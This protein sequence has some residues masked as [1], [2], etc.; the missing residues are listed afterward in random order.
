MKDRIVK[1]LEK[2]DWTIIK[3]Q[4]NIK[5]I[6]IMDGPKKVNIYWGTMTLVFLENGGTVSYHNRTLEQMKVLLGLKKDRWL[7]KV[8]SIFKIK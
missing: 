7:E 5:M 2:S 1:L 8:K 6:Q 4:D 3:D